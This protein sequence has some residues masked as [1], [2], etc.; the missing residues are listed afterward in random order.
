MSKFVFLRKPLKPVLIALLMALISTA[1]LVFC[2]QSYLDGLVLEHSMNITAYVGTVFSRMQEYPMLKEIPPE[3]LQKLEASDA[4]DNVMITPVYSGRAAGLT[5]AKDGFEDSEC[6]NMKLF[7]EGIVAKE[8]SICPGTF[9]MMEEFYLEVTTLWGGSW[10]NKGIRVCIVRDSATKAPQ[11]K[12]GDHVFLVGRYNFNAAADVNGML[13]YDP[14][15]LESQGYETDSAIW[16]HSILVLPENICQE[17]ATARINEFLGETGLDE[18]LALMDKLQ[19]MVTLYEVEDMSML[20]T[21][22]NETTFMTAGRELSANDT[23]S[24]VCVIHEALARQNGLAVGDTIDLSIADGC[25]I[26]GSDDFEAFLGWK[27]GYP[28]EG[29]TLLEYE[30]YGE[31][32]IVGL[33]SE[34]NRNLTGADYAHHTRNDIFIPSGI[35]PG[36]TAGAQARSVT[37]RV[38]GPN[39][40]AFMDAF[41]VPLNEQGYTLSI[42][43]TGWESVS[44]SFFALSD[45]RAVMT[46][47]TIVAFIAAVVSFDA[48]L[49]SHFRYEYA[50]RRLLGAMP[51]EARE[52]YTSAFLVTAI[53]AGLAA[54]LCSFGAYLLWLKRQ[55]SAALPAAIPENG[56]I[57]AYLAVW[58]AAEMAAAFAFL[59]VFTRITNKQ[60]LIKLLK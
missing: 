12:K 44:D 58:T 17:E 6:L 15:M 49:S 13:L 7:V 46:V 39:Y 60:S 53:P 34:I 55:I 20:L 29:D 25:Y 52:I 31:F 2:L 48:L 38:L 8:P 51:A 45:R 50:L 59:L 14:E 47:C 32:E 41:E 22:A 4:V 27:S 35:L 40:E 16:N 43:D 54:M 33:Y 28:Y 11:L 36:S 9:G 26:Y 1:M 37:F 23:G 56:A 24:R 10:P 42:I 5:H 3:I 19:D 21:V 18:P 57:L 30:P